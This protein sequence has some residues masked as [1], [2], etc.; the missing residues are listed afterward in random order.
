MASISDITVSL[1]CIQIEHEYFMEIG[2]Y[3]YRVSIAIMELK[4]TENSPPNAMEILQSLSEKLDLAKD[5]VEKCQK[6][7]QHISN[8]ELRSI[9]AELEK[10]IKRIGECLSLIPSSTFKEQ[11]YAEV[12]VHSLS[13]EMKN[14]SF[15]IQVSQSKDLDTQTLSLEEQPKQEL[16]QRETDLYSINVDVSMENPH[17]IDAHY[18]VKSTG[19]SSSSNRLKLGDMSRS[20]TSM[21]QVA[22]FMEPLYETFYCPLTKKIMDEP[23][24]IES[25]VTCEKKAITEWFDKHENT[26]E[27]FCPVTSQK[28][29][30]RVFNPNIA[31][32]CT[33][34]EWK[35]RNEV[36]RFK[37]ARA[38][39]SLASSEEMVLEAIRDVQSI[40]QR[41]P[42]NKLQIHSV[43]MLPLIIK[44]LEQKDRNVRLATLELLR[45]LAE[46][47]DD[48]KVWALHISN[49]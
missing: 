26:E 22:Q 39:L 12:A 10:M 42:H 11:E 15:V 19:S 31:L 18:L 28:L 38:A 41:K 20:F 13:K 36:A 29:V 48:S 3:L 24:T 9:I 25:G 37:V 43:G 17:F 5:P 47:D 16:T 45:Q 21:P 49:L 46:D 35:E 44:S 8:S 4:S 6:G 40:C 14:V 2:C 34:E 23:V 30:S 33:I 27:I 32:K 1:V 7:T